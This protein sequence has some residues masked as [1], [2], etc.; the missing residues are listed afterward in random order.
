VGFLYPSL[1]SKS[2][3]LRNRRGAEGTERREERREER[4]R[5]MPEG[6]TKAFEPKTQQGF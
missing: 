3:F 5:E 2:T 6:V 1:I 4:E